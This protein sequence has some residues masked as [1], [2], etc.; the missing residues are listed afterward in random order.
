MSCHDNKSK[1]EHNH[2]SKMMSWMMLCCL[3]PIVVL[4]I[5]ALFK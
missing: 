3:L 1:P 4:I 2:D 5:L